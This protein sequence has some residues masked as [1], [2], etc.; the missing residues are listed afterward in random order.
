MRDE[1]TEMW[2]IG[3]E[4]AVLRFTYPALGSGK[5]GDRAQRVAPLAGSDHRN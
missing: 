4:L 5:P 2:L 3:A 1:M